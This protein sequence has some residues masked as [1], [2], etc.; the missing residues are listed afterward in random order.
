MS[1]SEE[2]CDVLG[3][4]VLD[5]GASKMASSSA[6]LEWPCAESEKEFWSSSSVADGGG[7]FVASGEECM[8]PAA[9]PTAGWL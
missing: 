5:M 1:S 9:S 3:E 7:S 2:A 6:L 8:I 4:L